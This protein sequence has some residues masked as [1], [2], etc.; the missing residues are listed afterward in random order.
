[1]LLHV[2]TGYYLLNYFTCGIVCPLLDIIFQFL[3][4]FLILNRM[5]SIFPFSM[6]FNTLLCLLTWLKYAFLIL[7]SFISF[8]SG[9]C[10]YILFLLVFFTVYLTACDPCPFV[11]FNNIYII[12]NNIY[13]VL[14]TQKTKE[15]DKSYHIIQNW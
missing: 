12:F 10:W 7:F 15:K 11:E 13:I 9:L 8:F 2:V 6:Y 14:Y 5:P 4:V 3:F 1:M